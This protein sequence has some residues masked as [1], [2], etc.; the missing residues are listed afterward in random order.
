MKKTKVIIPAMGLLLLS[1]AA[2]ITG[3]VA[4]FAVNT[5][6][7]VT[8]LQVKAKAEGGIVIAPYSITKTSVADPT[9]EAP[10]RTNT[11]TDFAAVAPA[12]DSDFKNTATNNLGVAELYPTSTATASAWY[13]AVS[14][15][16]DN[17]EAADGS[18][19]PLTGIT[20]DGKMMKSGADGSENVGGLYA[21]EGEYFLYNKYKVKSTTSADSFGL[22]I[23]EINVT[24]SASNSTA[25]NKSLRVAVKAGTGAVKFFAPLYNAAPAGGFEWYNGSAVAASTAVAGDTY[26]TNNMLT[27]SASEVVQAGIDLEIWVYYEGEDENCKTS[28]AQAVTVDTLSLSFTFATTAA[29]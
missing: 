11:K 3:T 7:T 9:G 24:S 12:L 4:W 5:S 15:E 19:V 10:N 1:T 13:H 23:R 29:A 27:A 25:L 26:T 22:Y 8:G 20:T 14:S 16:Y 17:H 2:S 21:I 18:Y 6:V 28:N